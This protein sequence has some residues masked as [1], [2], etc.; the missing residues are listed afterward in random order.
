MAKKN[1]PGTF[2]LDK[3][4][5]ILISED[6]LVASL[7]LPVWTIREKVAAACNIM[8]QN[9]HDAG[10]SGQ[11]TARSDPGTYFTQSLGLGFDEIVPDN[12]LLVD[13]DLNVLAGK[14]VA[15]P[16]NRFHSWIYR[17]RPDVRCV[18][19][20]HPVHV[21]A[22]SITGTPL[23]V[24]QMDAC[25]LYEDVAFLADWPGIPVGNEEGEIIVNALGDKRALVLAH[26]GLV[27]ACA[28]VEEACVIAVQC[29]RAARMQ[30]LA[31]ATGTIQALAPD[32]AR[33]AHDWI[34]NPLRIEAAFHYFARRAGFRAPDTSHP[35]T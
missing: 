12:L 24:A 15:N 25:M 16:A 35:I 17:A 4:S 29:E 20:T 6:R 1:L 9:G 33:E 10:L 14:G 34:L 21:C 22:L 3:K 7:N 30:L 5:L 27:V 28:S 18:V 8:F 31:A 2:E 13:E 32:L 11:I 26:H 19:H 23:T